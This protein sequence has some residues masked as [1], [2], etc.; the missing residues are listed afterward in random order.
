M[1]FGHVMAVLL[2]VLVLILVV[3]LALRRKGDPRQVV[4]AGGGSGAKRAL[5]RNLAE[6]TFARL[7]PGLHGVGVVAVRPIPKGANPFKTAGRVDQRTIDLTKK[8]VDALPAEVGRMVTDF[9]E[10]D[11]KGL[12]P[13]PAHGLSTLDTTWYLNHSDAPNLDIIDDPAS[14]LMEFRANQPIPKGAELT[15]RYSDYS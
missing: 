12:Y 14:E 2:F 15:I 6:E 8:E 1:G 5:I 4:G 7:A 10:P 3:V 11:E 13:V 9:A